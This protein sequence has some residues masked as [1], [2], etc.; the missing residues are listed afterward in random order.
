MES[1]SSSSVRLAL[2]RA[3]LAAVCHASTK[4]H[5]LSDCSPGFP[6]LRCVNSAPPSVSCRSLGYPAYAH[7]NGVCTKR[8]GWKLGRAALGI[9][10]DSDAITPTSCTLTTHLSQELAPEMSPPKL[11]QAAATF[12]MINNDCQKTKARLYSLFVL[13]SID[14]AIFVGSLRINCAGSHSMMRSKR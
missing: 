13:H 12:V 1:T 10:N 7:T 4:A 5:F 14:Y 3:S 8:T 11:M 6:F 2:L 9:V